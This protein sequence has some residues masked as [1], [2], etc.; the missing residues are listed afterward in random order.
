MNQSWVRHLMLL[1]TRHL[2]RK[3]RHQLIGLHSGLVDIKLLTFDEIAGAILLEC[4]VPYQRLTPFARRKLI[5]RLMEEHRDSDELRLFRGTSFEGGFVSAVIH[6]IG[7]LKRAGMTPAEWK[8]RVDRYPNERSL[9]IAF[10]YEKYQERLY[11]DEQ[12]W[13]LDTEEMLIAAQ[14]LLLSH[15]GLFPR[16]QQ[17]TI[18]HF[19]DFTPLQLKLLYPLIDKAAYVEIRFPFHPERLQALP[20]LQRIQQ[21]VIEGLEGRGLKASISQTNYGQS[22]VLHKSTEGWQEVSVA[23]ALHGPSASDELRALQ[24]S[25]ML[26]IDGKLSI[27]QSLQLLPAASPKREVDIVALEV[28]RLIVEEN[29]APEDIAIILRQDSVYGSHIERTFHDV[30]VGIHRDETIPLLEIP[31]VKELLALCRLPLI[32]KNWHR[33]LLVTLA[34]SGYLVWEHPPAEGFLRWSM[35]AGV[36]AGQKQTPLSPANGPF[37][38]F[39]VPIQ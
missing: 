36:L 32:D 17:L 12:C 30:G 35:E 1:P 33:H 2:L 16:L 23:S 31:W 14:R 24:R 8:Q 39:L 29:V 25:W 20:H 6:Q 38:H 11:A 4:D 3:L 13:L 18:D 34:D 15:S 10:L 9:A 19:T 21:H 22:I 26:P 28:K 37:P 27:Q 7:E 5:Q